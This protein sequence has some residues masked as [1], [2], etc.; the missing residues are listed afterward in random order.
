[1]LFKYFLILLIIPY[2]I[3]LIIEYEDKSI[4]I[5]KIKTISL[6][7]SKVINKKKNNKQK[8]K[9]SI[10][11]K[12]KLGLSVYNSYS[13]V[14][15][16]H[17]K[18]FLWVKCGLVYGTGDACYT[19]LIYGM[20]PALTSTFKYCILNNLFFNKIT[21]CLYPYWNK[22]ILKSK[23]KILLVIVPVFIFFYIFI[24]IIDYISLIKIQRRKK[25]ERQYT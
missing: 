17:F 11:N 25:N 4:T 2:P 12:K 1:M 6:N 8:N 21:L 15:K 5:N 24:I 20:I 13:Y 23:V 16:M 14:S 7:S 3:F 9:K 18:P 22:K 19:G 10:I